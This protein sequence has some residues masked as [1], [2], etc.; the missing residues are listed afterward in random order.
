MFN[1]C[2]TTGFNN[3]S[4]TMDI[5]YLQTD[6]NSV[7]GIQLKTNSYSQEYD[8]VLYKL[9]FIYRIILLATI[10]L[11]D[12]FTFVVEEFNYILKTKLPKECSSK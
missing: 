5:Y 12:P 11:W 1:N 8:N 9:Y 10:L 2:S 6:Y 7:L 4:T 3:T